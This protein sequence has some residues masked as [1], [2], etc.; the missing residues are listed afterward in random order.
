MANELSNH[1]K[2]LK[3]AY[4]KSQLKKDV[5]S[6]G[7]QLASKAPP[8]LDSPTKLTQNDKQRLRRWAV[9]TAE[10][11]GGIG[12]INLLSGPAAFDAMRVLNDTKLTR[13]DRLNKM[14]EQFRAFPMTKLGNYGDKQIQLLT[15]IP[16][17][18]AT[19]NAP[20]LERFYNRS[21]EL[22]GQNLA[23]GTQLSKLLNHQDLY[24][25]HPWLS[26]SRVLH[27]GYS[28]NLGGYFNKTTKDIGIYGNSPLATKENLLHESTHA[29]ADKHNLPSGSSTS[30]Y[31]DLPGINNIRNAQ[32]NNFNNFN[33]NDIE[34]LYGKIPNDPLGR[35]FHRTLS[36]RFDSLYASKDDL[37]NE[38]YK[39]DLGEALARMVTDRAR[40]TTQQTNDIHPLMS[41]LLEGYPLELSHIQGIGTNIK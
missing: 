22:Q 37:A 12:S 29:I 2:A 6:V 39:S 28:K 40:Y 34:K 41:M 19:I 35:D 1:F 10:D 32:H 21:K 30:Y 31:M 33:I 20:V 24:S 38:L 36:D 5:Q 9:K 13:G 14:W 26:D 4:N 15:E 17:Q 25:A 27:R 16:D 18:L 11:V 8:K 3:E 7:K 23:P